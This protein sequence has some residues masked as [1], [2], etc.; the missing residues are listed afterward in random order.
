MKKIVCVIVTF[1]VVLSLV[2]CG[3]KRDS[4]DFGI[5]NGELTGSVIK[6]ETDFT[7]STDRILNPDIGFYR[8]LGIKL[9]DDGGTSSGIYNDYQL[10]HLRVNIAPFSKANNG[11]ADM[12]LT[13]AALEKLD[14]VLAELHNRE[15]SVIV[16]F[17]YDGFNGDADKEP[18]EEMILR[19]IEQ[20]CSVLNNYG[21]TLTAIEVGMVGKWGEM[22]T[23]KLANP[24]T[25]SKLIDAFLT[26]TDGTPVLVR[27]PKMIYDYLGIARNDIA[28]YTILKDSATYRLGLFN[29]GYL[30]SSTDL[31]TYTDRAAEVEW[32]SKQTEHL[33]YGGEVVVGDDERT[34]IK[35]CLPEMNKLNLSYLNYE[36]NNNITQG[37]WTK[38][39]YAKTIGEHSAYYGKTAQLYI[40]NHMGYRFVVRNLK[41][42]KDGDNLNLKLKIENVGFGNLNTKLHAELFITDGEKILSRA[43]A[44]DYSGEEEY[45]A[46][47]PLNGATGELSLYLRVSKTTDYKYPLYFANV[48]MPDAERKANLIAKISL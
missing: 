18:S 9:T 22:H 5:G 7:E 12:E 36:W 27:T 23:S 38:Q 42:A 40:E 47:I 43:A 32:L 44:P 16:R 1:I 25:I 34:D 4:G 45:T 39:K 2:G 24:Q 6:T 20:V 21:D 28:T 33:P 30:G 41:A 37:R 48:G 11:K 14:S 3:A 19:H 15:K 35:N 29:D 17:A 26:H 31:G 46:S 13:N 8:T 10:H